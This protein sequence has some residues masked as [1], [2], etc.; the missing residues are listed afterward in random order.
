MPRLHPT[1][2][3]GALVCL[4]TTAT[5]AHGDDVVSKI[6]AL[7][8]ATNEVLAKTAA[9]P[10]RYRVAPSDID[11]WSWVPIESDA[12]WTDTQFGRGEVSWINCRPAKASFEFSTPSGDWGIK[13]E[14]YFY[15][16]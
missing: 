4:A 14:Y 8:A 1:A 13:D 16:N 2:L 3:F 15:E 11:A 10:F 9:R 5:A 6:R 7:Y 12:R